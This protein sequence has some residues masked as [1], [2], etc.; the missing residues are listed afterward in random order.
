MAQTGESYNIENCS[1]CRKCFVR[2]KLT[3]KKYNKKV[4]DNTEEKKEIDN[5]S[6]DNK[7]NGLILEIKKK[8]KITREKI[9]KKK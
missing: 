5:V 2:K 6:E 4:Y 8:D 9:T 3:I 1:D 7:E